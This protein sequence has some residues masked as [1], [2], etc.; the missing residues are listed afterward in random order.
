MASEFPDIPHN[1]RRVYRRRSGVHPEV[2]RAASEDQPAAAF[3]TVVRGV[4]VETGQRR[5]ARHGVPRAAAGTGAGWVPGVDH[6]QVEDDHRQHRMARA[7]VF[8]NADCEGAGH[9]ESCP[10]ELQGSSGQ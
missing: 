9:G 3:A 8:C 4:G 6:E 5:T 2:D 1:M 7:L 10:E